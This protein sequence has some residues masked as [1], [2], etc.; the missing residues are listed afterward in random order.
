MQALPPTSRRATVLVAATIILAILTLSIAVSVTATGDDARTS[1]LRYE[2]LRAFYAAESGVQAAL[3]TQTDDGA[4]PLNTTVT[5]PDGS[6]CQVTDP[7][8]ASPA[9]PGLLVVEGRTTL[10]RRTISVT[11]Q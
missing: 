6:V 5:L 4:N 8:G 7:F 10:A 1:L 3:R 9:T 2:S 11:A